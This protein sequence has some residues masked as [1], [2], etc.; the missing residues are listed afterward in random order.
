MRYRPFVRFYFFDLLRYIHTLLCLHAQRHVHTLNT[1][2][3]GKKETTVP[4]CVL[5]FTAMGITIQLLLPEL[6]ISM[7]EKDNFGVVLII[8]AKSNTVK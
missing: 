8:L 5:L 4:L 2:G 3:T 7:K 6:R 1:E